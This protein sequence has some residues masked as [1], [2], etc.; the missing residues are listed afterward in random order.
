M[1]FD[2]CMKTLLATALTLGGVSAVQANPLTALA[3]GADQGS[4]SASLRY[5]FENVD[6]DNALDT[7]N[8]S[9][10]KAR[11]SAS[12]A[13]V[14]GWS[15]LLEM[16]YVASVGPDH[17]N[18][19]SNGN[20]E[21]SV[22][23]DPVGADLNQALISYVTG[24]SKV[25]AGRQRIL[26][27]NQRFV[28]GVG[29]R[30]NEQTYDALNYAYKAGDV[31]FSYS[32]VWNVNRIFSGKDPSVQ[33]EAFQSD[34]HMVFAT[35][36]G[37]N[38]FGYALDFDNAAAAS[39]LTF[40]LEYNGTLDKF[41]YGVAIA[42][43]SDYGSNAVDYDAMYYRATGSYAL[44]PVTLSAG[45]EVLGSDDG[46]ANFSTPL[47]TLH[48]FQG[49]VDTFL[50]T[51]ASTGLVNGM[52]DLSFGL[53]GKVGSVTLSGTWHDFSSDE[54]GIDY[55]SEIDFVATM[56]VV[57]NLSAQFK[58]ADYQADAVGVDTRKAWLM[59]SYTF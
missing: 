35:W 59:L 9:T 29:W 5:R 24:P 56:P 23:A 49:W 16:D 42:Q 30:Q 3:A 12:T 28:G 32:Y 17:Y 13:V 27:G 4:V 25:T 52:E 43:Q 34:S 26:H 57:E 7:A 45:Y 44:E 1:K 2:S 40:G 19:L 39:S 20:T 21:Y 14:D 33:A 38:A 51:G 54:G 46:V 10:L 31:S 15:G 37:F 18:S 47:A 53:S 11:L 50:S 55:G 58:Y 6:Q 48:A 36:K 8:A 41:K 22:V